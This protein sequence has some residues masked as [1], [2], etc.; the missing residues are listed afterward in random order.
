MVV[1]REGPDEWSLSK[2]RGQQTAAHSAETKG[3]CLRPAEPTV[4]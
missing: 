3:R 1:G 2:E 4:E